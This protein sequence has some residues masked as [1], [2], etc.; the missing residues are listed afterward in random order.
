MTD[1]SND[2]T[3]AS[4]QLWQSLSHQWLARGGAF[5]H[6]PTHNTVIGLFICSSQLPF[7]QRSVELASFHHLPQMCSSMDSIYPR[8]SW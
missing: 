1:P 3:L 8:I 2:I 5:S 6:S 4:E 7:D